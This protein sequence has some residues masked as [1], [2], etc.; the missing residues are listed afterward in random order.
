MS[1]S[2]FFLCLNHLGKKD[3]EQHCADTC[4]TYTSTELDKVTPTF[5]GKH[6]YMKNSSHYLHVNYRLFKLDYC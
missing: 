1:L 5:G 3:L 4:Y 6:Y 2:N